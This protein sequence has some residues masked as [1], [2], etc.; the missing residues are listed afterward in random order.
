MSESA[1]PVRFGFLGAG[2]IAQR[3]L[4]P[5]VHAAD[6]AVLQAVA[7][8]DPGR[9]AALE[10]AG[11]SYPDYAALLADPDVDVVYI[12]LNNDAHHEWTLAAL[13]AGKHV[14]CEKPLGL[15]V[16]EVAEMVEAARVADRLLVEAFWYRWHPRTRR[17]EQLLSIGALGPIRAMEADFSFSGA[18]QPDQAANYRLD[19]ARGGGAL[20]D[21]GCYPISAAH[22]VLGPQ[23]T[24]EQVDSTPGPTG[25]DLATTVHLRADGGAQAGGTATARCG[26]AVPDRQVLSV[27]G[28]GARVD[29]AAGEAFTNWRQPSA[30]TI[31]TPDGAVRAEEFAPVD[32]YRLMVE[33]TAA[34]VRGRTGYLIGLEH[35]LQVAATMA[36]A[37]RDAGRDAGRARGAPQL[38]ARAVV[39]SGVRGKDRRAP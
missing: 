36:E 2:W 3:A 1:V 20:Y 33:A 6:G 28:Q 31:T 25:V 10:P 17:L 39:R 15:D 30:L 29:F 32:A 35:S 13:A 34:R 21:V 14:L 5:A 27:L 9:A 38:N 24:V 8:R 22:L 23:L 18:D 7:A 37:G 11:R 19:P 4:G 26:I 12:C 16:A